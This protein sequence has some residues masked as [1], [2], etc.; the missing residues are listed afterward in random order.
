MATAFVACINVLRWV[1]ERMSSPIGFGC[2]PTLLVPGGCPVL[3]PDFAR[4]VSRDEERQSGGHIAGSLHY[5]SEKFE[6]HVVDLLHDVQGKEAVVFHCAKSQV[7][8]I[9]FVAVSLNTTVDRVLRP[10]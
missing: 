6:N 5:A 9:N 7:A 4:I 2:T 8:A 10:S 3:A 1:G